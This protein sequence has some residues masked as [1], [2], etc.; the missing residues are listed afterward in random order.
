M[1]YLYK[2]QLTEHLIGKHTFIVSLVKANIFAEETHIINSLLMDPLIL[3][4]TSIT[5]NG[6]I[7]S[8][9]AYM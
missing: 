9:Y 6:L 1:L 7:E 4:R 5:H 2:E 8:F 3:T